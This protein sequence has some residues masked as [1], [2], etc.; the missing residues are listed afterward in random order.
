MLQIRPSSKFR[1]DGFNVH[2]DV[3]VG[4]AQAAL[5]GKISVETVHGDTTIS[6]G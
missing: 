1:R 2:S 3:S 4:L 6:V 5:G